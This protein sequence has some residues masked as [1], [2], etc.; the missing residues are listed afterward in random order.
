MFIC[1]CDLRVL[2]QL[3]FIQVHP[4]FE[5]ATSFAPFIKNKQLDGGKRSADPDIN[6]YIMKENTSV[7]CNKQITVYAGFM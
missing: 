2:S 6:K 4:S 3:Q 7:L 1:M 5:L